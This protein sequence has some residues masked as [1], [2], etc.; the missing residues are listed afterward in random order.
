MD[1]VGP[2]MP[3]GVS[4]P[5]DTE[6][7]DPVMPTRVQSS[8]IVEFVVPLGPGGMLLPGEDGPGLG[9]IV[10]TDGLVPVAA[11]PLPA[12]SDPIIAQSS[13]EGLVREC[14]DVRAESITVYGGWSGPE[15]AGTPA[16]VAM[17]GMDAL[18][19]GNDAPLDCMDEGHR[20]SARD[21][22]WRDGL[23]WW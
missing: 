15:V 20:L 21:N 2:A 12:M 23:L 18:P 4:P 10:P 19:M 6:L 17:V 14:D 22:R 5:S 7:A 8:S 16:V 13:V 11:V 9:P 3:L 1:P